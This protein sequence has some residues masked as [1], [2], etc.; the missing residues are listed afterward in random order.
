MLIE[1]V[2]LNVIAHFGR[3]IVIFWTAHEA[4]GWPI[5]GEENEGCLIKQSFVLFCFVLRK[6]FLI[7]NF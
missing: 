3:P 2:S 6:S 4:F 7:F 1:C 5:I